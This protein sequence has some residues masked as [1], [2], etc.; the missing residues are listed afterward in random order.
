MKTQVE[1]IDSLRSELLR[2]KMQQY[3]LEHGMQ[4]DVAAIREQLKH[5]MK[6]FF[7]VGQEKALTGSHHDD[8]VTSVL[9]VAMPFALNSLVFKRSGFIIKTIV[10][11][12]SQKAAG[13]VNKDT[14]TNLI[15]K[16][17]GMVKNFK[18][19]ASSSRRPIVHR[20]YGIPPDSETY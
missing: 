3:Q 4:Q 18:F 9:R 7:G 12:A 20:D 8:W 17:T 1:N 10:T 11:L 14:F 15:D 16:V 19:P 6:L 2:L 5:P 13:I